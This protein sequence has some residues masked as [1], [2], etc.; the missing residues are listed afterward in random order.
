MKKLLVIGAV[1]LALFIGA[2]MFTDN[3]VV[4]EDFSVSSENTRQERAQKTDDN[5]NFFLSFA[6]AKELTPSQ[7]KLEEL[8]FYPDRFQSVQVKNK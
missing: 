4:E 8:G 1:L 2:K 6:A 5:K 3:K 7:K